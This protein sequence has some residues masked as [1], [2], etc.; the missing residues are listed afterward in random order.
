MQAAPKKAFNPNVMNSP[1]RPSGDRGWGFQRRDGDAIKHSHYYH[2]GFKSFRC[3]LGR[4]REAE[5]W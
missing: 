3:Y 2:P 4:S 1:S 5:V